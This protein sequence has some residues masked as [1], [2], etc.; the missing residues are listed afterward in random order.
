MNTKTI[1]LYD[2]DA[3]ATEFEASVLSCEN[4][5][6][7]YEIILD[8]TLFFPEE[9]G[10][11][12]D[13]GT[14]DNIPVVSVGIDDGVITH[15]LASP[16]ECGKK[17]CG[18]IDFAHRYRNMQHHSGEHIVSGL[19]CKTFGYNNVG[20]HLG[21]ADMTMDY[22]GELCDNDIQVIEDAANSAIYKNIEI[23]AEY[24]DSTKLASLEYRSKLDLTENVRI[25][26][27]GDYDVCACCAPHVAR[28]GEIG[29]IKIVDF[30][31]YKGGTRVHALCGADALA[32]YRQKDSVTSSLTAL[33]S[34]KTELI[35]DSVR[36]IQSENS[37]LCAQITAMTKKYS[38]ALAESISY[39]K[40][41]Y[42]LF[43]EQIGAGGTRI[44][45][46]AVAEKCGRCAVFDKTAKNRFNF[47]IISNDG[48]AK[49]VLAKLLDN[50]VSRGGGTDTMVQGSVEASTKEIKGLLENISF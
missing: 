33:L 32:D 8:K 1:K 15:I 10:Q 40:G 29:I 45:A 23:I 14:I 38:L 5:D 9:G 50:F 37:R 12:C 31:R 28:T 26:T 35:V 6:G 44:M 18:R 20:F 19:V 13:K 49:E 34:T 47:L 25:V 43:E 7:K 21:K 17:V 27:I 11:S 3:Y 42:V 24:P 39:K 48:K 46:T 30:Y 22:D 4:T 2:T 36:N 16:V 41:A